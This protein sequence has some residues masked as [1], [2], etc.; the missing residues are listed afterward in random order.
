MSRAKSTGDSSRIEADS[1]TQA[2]VKLFESYGEMIVSRISAGIGQP[3][4]PTFLKKV[5]ETVE[6][7][8]RRQVENLVKDY[9]RA[10]YESVTGDAIKSEEVAYRTRHPRR[11]RHH[12]RFITLSIADLVALDKEDDKQTAARTPMFPKELLEGI[13]NW[14][15]Q[16]LAPEQIDEVNL[17]A[18]KALDRLDVI[19]GNAVTMPDR[20][21]WRHLHELDD[22]MEMIVPALVPFLQRFKQ[23]FEATLTQ[24]QR[25]IGQGSGGKVQ[26]N[27]K[28]WD[29]LFA[30]MF[31]G[32]LRQIGANER[33]DQVAK[34]GESDRIVIADVTEQYRKW[35]AANQLK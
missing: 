27:A 6:P 21:L 28:L 14:T 29:L 10:T 32:L 25:A 31:G 26:L 8:L 24:M 35:R 16:I 33:P 17:A 1:R 4:D 11:R 2:F 5:N 30:R 7:I 9:Q 23:D 19:T 18:F 12:L 13:D 20:E 15:R 22:S 3:I 34:V